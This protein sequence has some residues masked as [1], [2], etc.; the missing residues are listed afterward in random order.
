[1][2]KNRPKK[3]D[4]CHYQKYAL[5]TLFYSLY[6]I[7]YSCYADLTKT[8]KKTALSRFQHGHHLS[9]VTFW[10]HPC[11]L[12]YVNVSCYNSILNSVK[13][14]SSSRRRHSAWS[15]LSKWSRIHISKDFSGKRIMR[16]HC[17]DHRYVLSTNRLRKLTMF[18]TRKVQGVQWCK[19]KMSE[20]YLRFS[21]A[22]HIS[23][24]ELQHMSC[25]CLIRY[26]IGY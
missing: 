16:R 5:S 12:Q 23:R 9:N 6:I 26:C 14:W 19:G 8:G 10:L 21:S 2:T 25:K 11:T 24:L 22:V 13:L 15:G 1:M 3:A 4:F 20:V 18:C 7:L 17:Q